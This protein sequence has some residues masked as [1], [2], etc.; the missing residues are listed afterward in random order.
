M[1]EETKLML[2][3]HAMNR[4]IRKIESLENSG[5]NLEIIHKMEKIID[6]KN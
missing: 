4:L 3:N 1:N 5:K 6:E 2:F